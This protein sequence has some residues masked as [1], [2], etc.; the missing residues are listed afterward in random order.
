MKGKRFLK[1]LLLYPVFICIFMFLPAGSFRFWEAWVYAVAI[2][3][4]LLITL[5]YLTKNDPALLERRLRLKEKEKKQKLIVKISRIPFIIG[6]L[7]PGLD[8]RFNWSDIPFSLIIIANIVVFFG[9]FLVFLVFRE[10][11]YTS[12]IV[13]IEKDQKVIS[14]GP[15]SYVRHPMYTGMILMFLATPIALGSWW[16]TIAFIFWPLILIIRIYNEEN[17]LCKDLPGY[18]KYCQK[19]RFRLIPYIW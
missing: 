10:N 15:Y 3:I 17:L 12:R 13:E 4:P 2:L 19:V 14:T 6:F 18:K 9:Y 8:Y 5:F 11:T 7:I 16:A 1:L